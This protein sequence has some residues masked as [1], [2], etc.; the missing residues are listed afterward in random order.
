M[1]NSELQVG[2]AAAF[3]IGAAF[4]FHSPSLRK[5]E[6]RPAKVAELVSPQG[7]LIFLPVRRSPQSLN[8]LIT[9]GRLNGNDVCISHPDVSRYHAFFVERGGELAVQDAGSTNGTFLDGV[10]VPKRGEGEPAALR[11]RQLLRFGSVSA[12]FVDAPEAASLLKDVAEGLRPAWLPLFLQPRS[13]EAVVPCD[14]GD[15]QPTLEMRLRDH[16][17][18]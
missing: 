10:A 14:E 16:G 18:E 9:L 8:P 4:D 12:V 5:T 6:P 13:C 2:S 15:S 17:I 7:A 1:S 3:L 11:S